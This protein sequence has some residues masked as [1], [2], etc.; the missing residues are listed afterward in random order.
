MSK[1]NHM[2]NPDN[3]P[4]DLRTRM[5]TR[6]TARPLIVFLLLAVVAA[7]SGDELTRPPALSKPGPVFLPVDEAFRMTV[8]AADGVLEIVWQIEEGYYLYRHQLG[9][10]LSA[11]H[12]PAEIPRG[13]PKHDE[14]FGDVE[15]YEQELTVRVPLKADVSG[16]RLE[17]RYQGCALAGLCY[18]PQKRQVVL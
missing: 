7:C 15:V 18:P 5:G 9:V 17:V 16:S 4:S 14:Y 3:Y 13:E 2:P 10:D 1:I 11:A 8:S 6:V 12:A